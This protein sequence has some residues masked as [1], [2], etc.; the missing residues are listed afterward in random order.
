MNHS[1]SFI[2]IPHSYSL[3][4]ALLLY[5]TLKGSCI[6]VRP[7]ALGAGGGGAVRWCGGMR[8]C[9]LDLRELSLDRKKYVCVI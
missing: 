4:I 9:H 8:G 5:K 1:E 7:A 6:D 2:F 3:S